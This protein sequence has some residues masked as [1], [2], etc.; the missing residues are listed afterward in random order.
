MDASNLKGLA[1]L[2]GIKNGQRN[3]MRFTK[4]MATRD[5]ILQEALRKS[6]TLMSSHFR[7]S[8]SPT[9]TA[10]INNRL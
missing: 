2:I 3:Y 8:K 9:K 6:K 10:A 1:S 7:S 5:E 4:G